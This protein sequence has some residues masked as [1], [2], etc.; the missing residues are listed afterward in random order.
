[1]SHILSVQTETTRTNGVTHLPGYLN[2]SDNDILLDSQILQL[3]QV[4]WLTFDATLQLPPANYNVYYKM[5]T[6]ANYYRPHTA[7]LNIQGEY[8]IT[9]TIGDTETVG[10]LPIEALH[11]P[12]D[13]WTWVPVICK[14]IEPE[15][16]KRK[17]IYESEN[18]SEDESED[19]SE[20]E[21]SDPVKGI[22][23]NIIDE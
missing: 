23:D 15:N 5:R 11:L 2:W 7:H 12:S 8:K 21:S 6:K 4:C 16:R 19:E 9:I 13:H 20:N 1:M 3:N 10:Y 17:R 18:E 22:N 14:P